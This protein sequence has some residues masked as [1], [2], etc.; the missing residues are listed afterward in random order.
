MIVHVAPLCE[1]ATGCPPIVSVP[2]LGDVDAFA[3]TEY[4]T[5]PSPE[6]LAPP[7]IVIQ[8]ASSVAV[9]PQPLPAV[10]ATSAVPPA[11]DIA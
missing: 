3:V 1:T 9:H 11:A 6:P 7:V 10:T 8:E 2:F 5:T 4:V